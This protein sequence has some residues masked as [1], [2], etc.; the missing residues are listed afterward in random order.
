[1]TALPLA[2]ALGIALALVGCTDQETIAPLDAGA[3]DAGPGDG[4]PPTDAGPIVRT[5]EIR[6]PFGSEPK[7]LLA[8]GD[9]E[10]SVSGG[11]GSQFAWLSYNAAGTGGVVTRIETGGL[12]RSGLRCAVMDGSTVMLLRGAAAP[13]M[14]AMTASIAIKPSKGATCNSVRVIA[15]PCDTLLAPQVQLKAAVQPETDGYC[16]S[17]G[18]MPGTTSA[19]CFY[20]DA[21]GLGTKTA[22]V[23]DAK[24]LP[25][26]AGEMALSAIQF[27]PEPELA[28]R[29]ARLRTLTRDRMPLGQP[30]ARPR[31]NEP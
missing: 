27:H 2:A 24:L 28:L 26:D 13:N 6:N 15:L 30:P 21:V 11:T 3:G 16:L 10:W 4:G 20:V 23:D 18:A 25:S 31:V 17:T 22:L 19:V 29:L 9:F 8:D 5:V 14:K 1:V 7:N 12:C